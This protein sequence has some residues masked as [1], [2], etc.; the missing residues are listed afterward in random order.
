MGSTSGFLSVFS[1]VDLG[2]DVAPKGCFGG[3]KI[4]A[5]VV[6]FIEKQCCGIAVSRE[7]KP[8][9][10]ERAMKKLKNGY[11]VLLTLVIGIALGPI[12][13]EAV[14]GEC[15]DLLDENCYA[16]TFKILDG[17]EVEVVS[18][19]PLMFLGVEEDFPLFAGI[20][21]EIDSPLVCYCEPR[22]FSFPGW[23][24]NR[25]FNCMSPF[26]PGGDNSMFLEGQVSIDA[27]VV[28]G[29]GHYIGDGGMQFFVYQC[30]L[31]PD[32]APPE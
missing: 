23:F 2:S 11:V 22:G 28:R 4:A 26:P 24:G 15:Q 1:Q 7:T 3:T 25:S 18:P 5:P 27:S 19:W 17:A 14:S 21:W 30:I 29:N 10:K 9:P 31:Y 20:T 13:A 6:T 12:T 32:C 8:Y 16:C